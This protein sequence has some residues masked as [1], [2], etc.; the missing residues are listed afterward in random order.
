M[1]LPVPR[2]GRSA[3]EAGGM[4]V[5]SGV[6]CVTLLNPLEVAEN[7]ATLDALTG[8]RFVLGAGLGDRNGENAAFDLP[9]ASRPE[10]SERLDVI[11]RLLEGKQMKA[12]G[13]RTG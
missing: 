8:G 7:V 9:G 4:R 2:L 5:G 11:R 1:A 6:L 13:T 12:T 10:R 3:A